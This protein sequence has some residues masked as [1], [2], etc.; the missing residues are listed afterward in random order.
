M[1]LDQAGSS[2]TPFPTSDRYAIPTPI[3]LRSQAREKACRGLSNLHLADHCHSTEKDLLVTAR[4][5]INEAY[6]HRADGLAFPH[7]EKITLAFGCLRGL[8]S[9]I[10]DGPREEEA[11]Q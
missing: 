9:T 8:L 4:R 2:V 11:S 6:R 7:S 1:R 3:E 10:P 5:A